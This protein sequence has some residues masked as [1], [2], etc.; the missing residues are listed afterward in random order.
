MRAP[1]PICGRRRRRA[2]LSLPIGSGMDGAFDFDRM[3]S[4]C[5]C[6]F[7]RLADVAAKIVKAVARL[8]L[9]LFSENSHDQ[10][11]DALI[12]SFALSANGAFSRSCRM[13][14]SDPSGCTNTIPKRASSKG[15]RSGA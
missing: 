4:R 13:T 6:L 9:R 7:Y 12:K 14:E 11:I 1:P 15:G 3:D 8:T 10:F 5:A 2:M